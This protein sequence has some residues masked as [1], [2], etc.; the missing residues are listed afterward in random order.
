MM[1]RRL[2]KDS[3]AI[4][5]WSGLAAAAALFAKRGLS[6][7]NGRQAR[8]T[9]MGSVVRWRM[10]VG[11]R[12]HAVVETSIGADHHRFIPPLPPR[13]HMPGQGFGPSR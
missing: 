9:S 10:R 13:R 3:P 8:C 5:I 12:N 11:Q 4:N 7:E 6:E 2:A 1:G